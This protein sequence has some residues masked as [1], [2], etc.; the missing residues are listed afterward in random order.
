MSK[1]NMSADDLNEITVFEQ[2]A[3]GKLKGDGRNN[4]CIIYTRVSSKEQEQGYSLDIQKKECE[5][6][7]IKNNYSRRDL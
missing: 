6:L 7:A 4:N 1:A 5:E 2:F 3:K